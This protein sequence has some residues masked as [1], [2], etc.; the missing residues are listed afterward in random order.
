MI[1]E[2]TRNHHMTSSCVDRNADLIPMILDA[3]ANNK[4]GNSE[5]RDICLR[6][7]NQKLTERGDDPSDFWKSWN[8]L[9]QLYSKYRKA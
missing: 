7:I 2:S 3:L 1:M 6:N 8:E 9:V 5:Q 4:A